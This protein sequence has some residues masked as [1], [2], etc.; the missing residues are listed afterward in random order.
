MISP[1]PGVAA[2]GDNRRVRIARP[3]TIDEYADALAAAL[4]GPRRLRADLVAEAR[5]GLVDAA[6]AYEADG[7]DRAAAEH[8]AIEDFGELGEIAAAY[9]PELALAQSRRSAI[10]LTLVIMIQPIVWADGRWPWN[11]GPDSSGSWVFQLLQPAIQ[12]AGLVMFLIAAAAI[13]ACGIGVRRMS[14]RRSA[15]RVS[16]LITLVSAALLATMATALGLADHPGL[17]ISGVVWT[18]LFVLGPS[19]PVMISARRA[20]ALTV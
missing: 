10:G 11:D 9:R 17:A 4:R 3:D 16:S 7:L 15:A 1:T 14:I 5:D 12:F 18:S 8:R 2:A 19:I 20:L 13:V 6:E